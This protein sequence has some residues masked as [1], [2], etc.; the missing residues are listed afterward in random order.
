MKKAVRPDVSPFD[1]TAGKANTTLQSGGVS[2]QQR[3]NTLKR[4][5][6]LFGRAKTRLSL[7]GFD[8]VF[9]SQE[10]ERKLQ[11]RADDFDWESFAQKINNRAVNHRFACEC[12]RVLQRFVFLPSNKAW[13]FWNLLL[14]VPS[15][16]EC[17]VY[18][19]YTAQGFPEDPKDPMY[20]ILLGASIFFFL[21]IF[22]NF[23]VARKVE[24]D[25]S[26]FIVHIEKL[27]LL[28]L[29]ESFGVKL[30]VLAPLGF[31]FEPYNRS[32]KLLH[33]IK[34][35]RVESFFKFFQPSFF[36][37]IIRNY[38][39]IK[40]ASVLRDDSK[41]NNI[42]ESN[43][44]IIERTR[45]RNYINSASILTAILATIYFSSIIWYII[46]SEQAHG[47]NIDGGDFVSYFGIDKKDS[48]DR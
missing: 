23:F 26:D 15:L 8:G 1:K 29:K 34:L 25:E 21:D 33:L 18:P 38:Y 16:I 32:L 41:K 2:Q 13:Y 24:G 12:N 11:E 31:V 37:P 39:R 14:L 28:Y 45:T 46:T 4:V 44:F 43:N 22:M 42:I 48:Q 7:R 47:S 19:Y 36:G 17:I 27:G 9:H 40:L 30:V 5:S 20:Y 6:T 10:S 3:A 35:Q